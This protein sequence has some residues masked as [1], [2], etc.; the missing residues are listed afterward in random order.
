MILFLIDPSACKI[1]Q[2]RL[3]AIKDSEFI[4]G[5]TYRGFTNGF[6]KQVAS[7]L[8]GRVI[9]L[10]YGFAKIFP[11]L[12]DHVEKLKEAQ[13]KYEEL[14]CT[15]DARVD[16]QKWRNCLRLYVECEYMIKA[17]EIVEKVGLN[18]LLSTDWFLTFEINF[19]GLLNA[20]SCNDIDL[21]TKW[22][23]YFLKVCELF[24]VDRF[25]FDPMIEDNLRLDTIGNIPTK[26][27]AESLDNVISV[28]EKKLSIANPDTSVNID[29]LQAK[30]KQLRK[31]L[32]PWL[33][34]KLTYKEYYSIRIGKYPNDIQTLMDQ[35]PQYRMMGRE[36]PQIRE[37][38][39]K[40]ER[41]ELEEIYGGVIFSIS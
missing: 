3:E 14:T 25:S 4:H 5:F 35:I 34:G 22:K 27:F 21:I 32:E 41:R 13:E 1:Y 26:N 33:K 20:L 12:T 11:S 24:A 23:H 9:A 18:L 17:T 37:L 2:D 7:N 40:I 10:P 6:N 36:D 19:H 8:E 16:S 28:G 39:N 29:K 30:I 15:K 31:Y 38:L